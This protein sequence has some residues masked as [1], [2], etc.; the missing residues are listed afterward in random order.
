MYLFNF[1]ETLHVQAALV[2]DYPDLEVPLHFRMSSYVAENFPYGTHFARGATIAEEWLQTKG[3]N[4]IL[5]FLS[6]N[7]ISPMTP[8]S[9]LAALFPEGPPVMSQANRLLPLRYLPRVVQ[10]LRNDGLIVL[11]DFGDNIIQAAPEDF[12]FDEWVSETFPHGYHF[13]PGFEVSQA[14]LDTPG[15][16]EVIDNMSVWEYL[17]REFPDGPRQGFVLEDWMQ[18]NVFNVPIESLVT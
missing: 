15:F 11:E 16:N 6:D 13:P 14:W 2:E 5:P 3:F 18:D 12:N 7:P 17:A 10:A 9:E 1:E 8:W 4:K